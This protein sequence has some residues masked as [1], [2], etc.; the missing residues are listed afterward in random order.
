[1]STNAPLSVC[2]SLETKVRGAYHPDRYFIE[3]S[4][5]PADNAA[6]YTHEY[7]HYLQNITTLHGIKSFLAT[8]QL[9]ARFSATMRKDGTSE[10]DCDFSED[11]LERLGFWSGWRPLYEGDVGP[12][13]ADISAKV[14]SIAGKATTF[15]V[16]WTQRK[17]QKQITFTLGAHA[18]KESVAHI[19]HRRVATLVGEPQ[20]NAP[21]F[22]YAVLE[23]VVAHLV[24][25]QQLDPIAVAA[26]G[27]LALL[28]RDPGLA[29]EPLVK[30]L[31]ASSRVARTFATP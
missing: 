12:Q 17:K 4:V 24:P 8:Q 28:C 30:S 6:T 22:P 16:L 19:V 23:L 10:G 7:W 14:V 18:I 21:V 3:M 26:I 2:Q 31:S 11:D 20:P 29:V 15:D 5:N 1:M 25:D 9:L 27:T 13:D